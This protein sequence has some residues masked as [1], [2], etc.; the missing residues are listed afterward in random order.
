MRDL[1]KHLTPIFAALVLVEIST[2]TLANDTDRIIQLEKEVEELRVRLSA[3]ENQA[4]QANNQTKTVS[5]SD[6]WKYVKSWRSLKRGMSY[7][8]V[9]QILG[10]PIR[11]DGGIHTYWKYRNDGVVWFYED[12]LSSWTEPRKAVN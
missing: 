10:E 1:T 5:L 4:S 11:I 9:R 8:E 12:V 3:L 6:G 2:T 7:T